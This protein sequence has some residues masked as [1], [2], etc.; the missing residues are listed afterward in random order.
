M[1]VILWAGKKRKQSR[2]HRKIDMVEI[3]IRRWR[4]RNNVIFAYTGSTIFNY[5][6]TLFDKHILLKNKFI[7]NSLGD[8]EDDCEWENG[9]AGINSK[10]SSA[11]ESDDAFSKH[12][13]DG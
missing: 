4:K 3:N 7:T 1:E 10:V 12:G 2:G 8:I 6:F 11:I 9:D 13:T 5:Y